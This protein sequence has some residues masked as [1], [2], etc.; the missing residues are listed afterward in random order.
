MTYVATIKRIN[1]CGIGSDRWQRLYAGQ[2]VMLMKENTNPVAPDQAVAAYIDDEK[3]GYVSSVDIPVVRIVI[4]DMD[5]IVVRLEECHP[6]QDCLYVSMEADDNI[7]LSAYQPRLT[8]R[9]IAGITLPQLNLSRELKVDRLTAVC[10]YI[11]SVHTLINDAHIQDDLFYYAEQMTQLYGSSLSG[12]D[13]RAVTGLIDLVSVLKNELGDWDMLD[14]ELTSLQAAYN[15]LSANC[16]KVWKKELKEAEH[17]LKT[18]NGLW[19]EL[20]ILLRKETIAREDLL[21]ELRDW[22]NLLPHNLFYL[23][24]TKP[25]LFA[26]RLYYERFSTTELD[27]IKTYLI[28]HAYAQAWEAEPKTENW[29]GVLFSHQ[30]D[31]YQRA[32]TKRE[33][34]RFLDK[35]YSTPEL[36]KHIQSLV[37]RGILNSP[38]DG[39]FSRYCR[40]L[41]GYFGCKFDDANFRKAYKNT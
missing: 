39:N 23:Y 22:L 2:D 4:G 1:Q 19:D 3:W 34:D 25:A 14:N 35:P 33:M 13:F 8:I 10:T 5:G 24:D 37:A 7:Q 20:T 9:P 36:A 26:Q 38:L 40:A 18:K 16:L 31:N 17:V 28:I 27:A 21:D 15:Q 32:T 12:D 30:I 29:G 6:E 11:A 41:K